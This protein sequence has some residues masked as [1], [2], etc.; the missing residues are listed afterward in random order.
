MQELCESIFSDKK[1][2]QYVINTLLSDKFETKL[3][4]QNQRLVTELMNESKTIRCIHTTTAFEGLVDL[5][6]ETP[7]EI[8]NSIKYGDD[9]EGVTM[10]GKLQETRDIKI[11][12]D[13]IL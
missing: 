9:S 11:K 4:D 13:K 8:V 12:L 7:D 2:I 3:I 6:E 10:L 1:H 5:F